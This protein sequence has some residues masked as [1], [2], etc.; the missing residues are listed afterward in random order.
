MSSRGPMMKEI[1]KELVE[2][3]LENKESIMEKIN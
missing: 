2:L 1:F 3:L